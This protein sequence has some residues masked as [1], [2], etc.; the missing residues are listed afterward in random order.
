MH[1]QPSVLH[2]FKILSKWLKFRMKTM[3]FVFILRS[4]ISTKRIG[5]YKFGTEIDNY[6]ML[7]VKHFK[8][9]NFWNSRTYFQRSKHHLV[10]NFIYF[11]SLFYIFL[12]SWGNMAISWNKTKSQNLVAVTWS[13]VF[14]MVLL[15]IF[16]FR[17][18]AYILIGRIVLYD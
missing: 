4:V 7:N 13:A 3:L 12:V 11:S 10:L 9:W 8:F 15:L 6:R 1:N 18:S 5:I 17:G 16:K 2:Y 14:I